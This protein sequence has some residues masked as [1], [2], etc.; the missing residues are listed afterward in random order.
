M[1]KLVELKNVKAFHRK[2][3]ILNGVNISVKKGE[4][5]YLIGK[6]GSGKSSILKVL[7]KEMDI[8]EGE[9]EVVGLDLKKL[10][11][12]QVHKLRRQLG[13]VFQDFQ[14]L[15][16]RSI[17]DNL[18]FIM[19]STGWKDKKAMKNH[20]KVTL[21]QVNLPDIGDK[22]P[23][24]L[25]GGQQQKVAIARAMINSPKVILAD[26]PTGNLDPD[27][28]REIMKLLSVISK[29]GTA[30]LMATHDM[31]LVENYPGRILKC[32]EGLISEV[33]ASEYE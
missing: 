28:S 8:A 9:G 29:G 25:S 11:Y 26:E 23:H 17:E 13:V 19:K 1:E 32:E 22:Y 2:K 24:Q 21:E 14:L 18:L 20:A 27:S 4:F 3:Q 5:V 33:Q 15:P 12:T 30:I 10:K 31:D 7:Y 6:T 16:D